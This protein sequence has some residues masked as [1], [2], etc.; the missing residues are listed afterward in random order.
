MAFW[1]SM[2]K[3]KLKIQGYKKTTHFIERQSQRKVTDKQVEKALK[4]GSPSENEDGYIIY[5]LAEFTVVTD[6][7]SKSL[8]TVHAEGHEL[9]NPKVISLD[10]ARSIKAEI[11]SFEESYGKSITND[12][13]M[14][15]HRERVKVMEDVEEEKEEGD[16]ISLEDYL[17]KS[18]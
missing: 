7:I 11:D 18:A 14:E 4:K 10:V 13:Y 15:M 3:L 1:T 6:P 2:A 12:F 16:V 5:R 17:K 9:K 8:V